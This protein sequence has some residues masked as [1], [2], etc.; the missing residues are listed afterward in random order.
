MDLGISGRVAVITGA[1]R[2]IGAA[3]ADILEAEGVRVL[4]VSRGEG[5]DVTADP[6]GLVPPGHDRAPQSRMVTESP[7]IA[8]ALSPL[9]HQVVMPS[10]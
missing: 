7:V 4:R 5:I 10:L 3:T 6:E 8:N 9:V 2:G 1:T